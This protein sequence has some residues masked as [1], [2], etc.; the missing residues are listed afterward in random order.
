MNK[1][2]GIIQKMM[3]VLLMAILFG[4]YSNMGNNTH[5]S[6]L[7]EI[8]KKFEYGNSYPDYRDLYTD[9]WVATD[10]LGRKMPSFEDVGILKDDK[11]RV[12]GIF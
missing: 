4:A 3:A 12:V 2:T 9:T 5:I 6:D 1:L 10:A 11:R 8:D 7:K